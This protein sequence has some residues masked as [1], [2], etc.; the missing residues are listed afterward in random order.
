L[1][2]E[3]SKNSSEQ[4]TAF[5]IYVETGLSTEEVARKLQQYGP[6]EIPEKKASPFRKFLGLNLFRPATRQLR[7][8]LKFS[9]ISSSNCF[10]SRDSDRF[11]GKPGPT[12]S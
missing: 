2:S 1:N 12:H 8:Q 3:E 11:G 5:S 7:T 6:N 4:E 9:K 10:Q